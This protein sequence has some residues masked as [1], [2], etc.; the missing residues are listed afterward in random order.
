MKALKT[1]KF[2][3]V[4]AAMFAFSAC[5]LVQEPDFDVTETGSTSKENTEMGD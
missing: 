1:I 2:V 5:E 4:I 3:L